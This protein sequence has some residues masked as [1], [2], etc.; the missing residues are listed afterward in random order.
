MIFDRPISLEPQAMVDS[1]VVTIA[2]L[3]VGEAGCKMGGYE[4]YRS[5][6]V[7]H[8]DC[9]C[10]FVACHAR[11]ASLPLVRTTLFDYWNLLTFF[12]LPSTFLMNFNEF[13]LTKTDKLAP[14]SCPPLSITYSSF[15]C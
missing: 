4:A 10:A 14:T 2:F 1:L 11:H 15:P 3:V 6:G 7:L 12:K 13:A 8:A 9:H 5:V